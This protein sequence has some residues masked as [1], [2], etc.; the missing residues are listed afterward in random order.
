MIYT[1]Q[2]VRHPFHQGALDAVPISVSTFIFE[3]IFG[4]V[5]IQ[6]G[7]TVL[8]SSL[9]SF[10][11]FAGYILGA[12]LLGEPI[13]KFAVIGTILV[14]FGLYLSGIFSI[15][16]SRAVVTQVSEMSSE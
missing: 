16:P 10:I 6:S 8:E 13:T 5:S 4:V 3:A 12:I 1:I 9:M 15:K 7:L 2:K 14:L 11:Y